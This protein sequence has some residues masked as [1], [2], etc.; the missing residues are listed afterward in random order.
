MRATA[1]AS[2][3]WARVAAWSALVGG[4]VGV[5]LPVLD[6]TGVIVGPPPAGMV[7]VNVVIAVLAAAVVWRSWRLVR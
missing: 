3:K 6:L 2:S 4:V 5:L 7:V 1:A